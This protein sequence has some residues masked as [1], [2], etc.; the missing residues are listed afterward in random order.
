MQEYASIQMGSVTGKTRSFTNLL[1]PRPTHL[2][3]L[4]VWPNLCTV[5]A[6]FTEALDGIV[7]IDDQLVC[8]EPRRIEPAVTG[9]QFLISNAGGVKVVCLSHEVLVYFA[10]IP[11]T[12]EVFDGDKGKNTVFWGDPE[13]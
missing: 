3:N 5:V 8:D 13:I 7:E 9:S 6:L 2:P 1:R 12:I 10:A 11:I 4:L